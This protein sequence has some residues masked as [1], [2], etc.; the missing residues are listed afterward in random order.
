METSLPETPI[1]SLRPR[2]QH[3]FRRA[4]L[5]GLGLLLPPL[6]TILLF[7]WVGR[8]IQTNVLIPLESIACE[9]FLWWEYDAQ[10]DIPDSVAPAYVHRDEKGQ[11]TSFPY[12]GSVYVRLPDGTWI[13]QVVYDR[14]RQ[15]PG[16]L[17]LGS[18]AARQYYRQYVRLKYLPP[19]I[20]LPVFLGVFVVVLYLLGKFLAAGVG[21]ILWNFGEGLIHRLPII[22]NVYSSVKQVTDLVFSEQEIQFNRV[23]A[24]EY[25][26][27][28]LWSVGFVTSESLLDI[29]EATREP[30]LTVF[31]PTSPM[32]ATGFTV[33]VCKSET[34][35][36][37]I[38]LDQA[39]QFIVSCGVV[40][41]A[42]QQT[43]RVEAAARIASALAAQNSQP[44]AGTA[45]IPGASSSPAV[46]ASPP[47]EPLVPLADNHE[48][49]GNGGSQVVKGG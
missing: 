2:R 20:V 26:R 31:L 45:P 34:L 1:E 43:Q 6:L 36:L 13:R 17:A 5:R 22:R 23:V 10:D 8:T 19:Y 40:I 38:S 28:G 7:V 35:D 18:A 32:P 4:V 44:P 47:A 25:P 9:A 27:K 16:D 48:K 33:N 42:H 11:P 46:A 30:M 3:P 24:V 29:R 37:D 12:E 39:I 21:R 14:V 41:P 49:P 15:R